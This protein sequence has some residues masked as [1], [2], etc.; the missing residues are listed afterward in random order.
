MGDRVGDAPEQ[1][2]RA[3]HSHTA[4]DEDV[5]ALLA[6]DGDDLP[7]RLSGPDVLPHVEVAALVAI[8]RGLES[9]VRLKVGSGGGGGLLPGAR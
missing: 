3:P 2:S 9:D 6:G 5:R 7:R 1:S 8:E 4:E